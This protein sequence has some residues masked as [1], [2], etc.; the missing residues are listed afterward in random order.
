MLNFIL[1]S[2]TTVITLAIWLE[3]DLK[4]MTEAEVIKIWK[5]CQGGLNEKN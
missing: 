4:T 1:G 3:H 2:V 5:K